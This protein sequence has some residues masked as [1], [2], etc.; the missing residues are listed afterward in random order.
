M[1]RI[2]STDHFYEHP[3]QQVHDPRRETEVQ[4]VGYDFEDKEVASKIQNNSS[5]LY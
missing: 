2:P 3:Q 1:Y 4:D 5:F